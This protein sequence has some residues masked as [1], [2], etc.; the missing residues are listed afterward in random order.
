ML[1]G[2]LAEGGVD[3]GDDD[4]GGP[5]IPLLKMETKVL[6]ACEFIS[7]WRTRRSQSLGPGLSS[8]MAC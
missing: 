2:M 7:V 5:C 6:M 1:D 4:A 8:A 3:E